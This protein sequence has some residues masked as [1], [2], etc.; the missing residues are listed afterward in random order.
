PPSPMLGLLPGSLALLSI[1]HR[2]ISSGRTS[3]HM[4]LLMMV[5]L[6]DS[7]RPTGRRIGNFFLSIMTPSSALKTEEHQSQAKSAPENQDTVNQTPEKV[8][9]YRLPIAEIRKRRREEI[10][11]GLG[12]IRAAIESKIAAESSKTVNEQPKEAAV[13]E[14]VTH[15]NGAAANLGA[16]ISRL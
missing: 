8:S 1:L 2:Y 13:K 6:M 14:S 9:M 10:L 7:L 16:G 3:P 11:E 12:K 5:G 4:E 15:K